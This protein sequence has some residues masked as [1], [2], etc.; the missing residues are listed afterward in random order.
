ME[1]LRFEVRLKEPVLIGQ[2]ET[3]EENSAKTIEYIP[4]SVLRGM[5]IDYYVRTLGTIQFDK[6]DLGYRLFFSGE[7]QY[8]HGYPR[9]R[10]GKRALPTPRSWCIQK[11]DESSKNPPIQNLTVPKNVDSPKSP[12]FPFCV[13]HEVD[14]SGTD[15][16]ETQDRLVTPVWV[17]QHIGLHNTSSERFIKRQTDSTVYRYDA[18]AAEQ[19]FVAMIR[20]TDEML[21]RK[22]KELLSTQN[23]HIGRSRRAGYGAIQIIIDHS[24]QEQ[25]EYRPSRDLPLLTFTLLS[26]VVLRESNGQWSTSLIEYFINKGLPAPTRIFQSSSVTGGFNRTW[27]LPLPQTPMIC[28]GSVYVFERDSGTETILQSLVQSGIGER[29]IEGFGQVAL[30]WHGAEKL[31]QKRPPSER[32]LPTTIKLDGAGRNLANTIVNR[33]YQRKLD[34]TLLNKVAALKIQSPPENSQL[35]R[36]RV[37]VRQAQ[38]ERKWKVVQDFLENLRSTAKPQFEQARIDGQSFMKW[39]DNGF[40]KEGIWEKHFATVLA[41]SPQIADTSAVVD[42]QIKVDTLARLVDAICRKASKEEEKS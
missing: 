10:E 23:F 32:L 24:S 3:G 34:D 19:S 8:L 25:A 4:G 26:D 21:L 11:K 1:V 18:L 15:N 28:A 5:L 37:I 42:E 9:S 22:L 13:L 30:N 38:E 14:E 20:A 17:E 27:G 2:V 7:V 16:N 33:L 35:S 39:L 12:K 6:A 29:K 41:D 36:L 31:A 40:G